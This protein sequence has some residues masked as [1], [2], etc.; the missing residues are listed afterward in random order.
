MKKGKEPLRTFGDLKQ[1]FELQTEKEAEDSKPTEA[2]VEPVR[3]TV[4]ETVGETDSSP[5]AS[6]AELA[7]GGSAELAESPLPQ[8]ERQE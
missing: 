1:F 2:A 8:G 7:T 3:E 5:P 4:A 6:S